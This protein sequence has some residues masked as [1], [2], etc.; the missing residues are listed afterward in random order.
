MK[1]GGKDRYSRWRKKCRISRKSINK[2]I[3]RMNITGLG[4]IYDFLDLSLLKSLLRFLFVL[5]SYFTFNF[6]KGFCCQ[7]NRIICFNTTWTSPAWTDWNLLTE[8]SPHLDYIRLSMK[9][10]NCYLE[11]VLNLTL[12][13][14]FVIKLSDQKIGNLKWQFWNS[15]E[16]S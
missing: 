11:F 1:I 8:N 2:E 4:L 9:Y 10:F 15:S 6:I 7:K 16:T 14:L 5:W 3:K 13:P 12:K